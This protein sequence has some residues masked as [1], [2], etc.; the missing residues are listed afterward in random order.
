MCSVEWCLQDTPM[1]G[2][3]SKGVPVAVA[4][5]TPLYDDPLR[6]PLPSAPMAPVAPP[7]GAPYGPRASVAAPAHA[8]AM[9]MAPPGTVIVSGST[10]ALCAESPWS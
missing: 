6:A 5:A 7:P 9:A 4:I 8:Q 3:P 1:S 2:L 10:Q